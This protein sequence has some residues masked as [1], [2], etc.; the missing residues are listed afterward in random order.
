MAGKRKC[1]AGSQMCVAVVQCVFREY[2]LVHSLKLFSAKICFSNLKCAASA[3]PVSGSEWP[4]CKCAW[5]S[6]KI[7]TFCLF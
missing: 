1:A 2:L 4:V 5:P 6:L 3:W 7:F